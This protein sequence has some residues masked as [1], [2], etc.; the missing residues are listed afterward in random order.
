M[1]KEIVLRKR[2]LNFYEKNKTRGKIFTVRHFETEGYHKGTI[3]R[4][5]RRG[6]ITRKKDLEKPILMNKRRRKCLVRS[7][8]GSRY[9]SHSKLA[10]K[11]GISRSYCRKILN[12]YSCKTYKKSKAPHLTQRQKSLQE[13]RLPL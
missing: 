9:T 7:A 5:I 3:Y 12:T 13:E 2:V 11:Y 6:R 10:K 1:E 4:I 8:E